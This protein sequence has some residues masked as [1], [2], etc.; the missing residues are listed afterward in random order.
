MQVTLH[1]WSILEIIKRIDTKQIETQTV[2]H[3]ITSCHALTLTSAIVLAVD[4]IILAHVL[5]KRNADNAITYYYT[6]FQVAYL[7]I[8]CWNS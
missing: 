4:G 3:D 6:M 7:S 8:K 5:V 1:L 2:R